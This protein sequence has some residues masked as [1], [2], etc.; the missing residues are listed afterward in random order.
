[1]AIVDIWYVIIVRNT[2][3]VQSAWGACGGERLGRLAAASP[4]PPRVI[5]VPI[6]EGK[7]ME[8]VPYTGEIGAAL[9]I[10]GVK[11]SSKGLD[12]SPLEHSPEK[13]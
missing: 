7:Q 9:Y 11:L 6:H 10:R 3:T 13:T 1:M 2:R 12:I 5:G 8:Q 4:S